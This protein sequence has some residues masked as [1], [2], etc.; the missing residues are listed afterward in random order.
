MY[1]AD[2]PEII[3]EVRAELLLQV[4]NSDKTKLADDLRAR[5]PHL[6]E[7]IEVRARGHRG[8]NKAKNDDLVAIGKVVEESARR[9]FT[10]THL[11]FITPEGATLTGSINAIRTLAERIK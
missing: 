10:L 7:L 2:D 8:A 4:N 9:G 5:Y 11:V 6:R 1:E 3:E